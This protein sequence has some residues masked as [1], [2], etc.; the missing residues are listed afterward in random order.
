MK[1]LN[2]SPPPVAIIPANVPSTRRGPDSRG[3]RICVQEIGRS[4]S[5]DMGF[6]TFLDGSQ[7]SYD[8]SSKQEF[9]DLC[10]SVIRGRQFNFQ[11]RRSRG[12]YVRSPTL[13]PD[14]EVIYSYPPYKGLTPADCNICGATNTDFTA[15][16][17]AVDGAGNPGVITGSG[18]SL[19][20][21][22]AAGAGSDW[23]LDGSA[24]C[25]PNPSNT[26]NVHVVNNGIFF[27]DV[28]DLFG[29]HVPSPNM[30]PNTAQDFTV[31]IAPGLVTD[32]IHLHASPSCTNTV[33]FT[34]TPPP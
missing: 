21:A 32:V 17:W 7:Y 9:E 23:F 3:I 34:I 2:P 18:V 12:G 29:F 31:P 11:V 30:S 24:L 10:A 5:L 16:T 4:C 8:A 1:L 27:L 15:V 26:F 25:Y 33:D 19:S 20:F 22:M 28:S 6:V 14:Y 13:P